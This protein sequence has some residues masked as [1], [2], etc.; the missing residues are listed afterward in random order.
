[1]EDPQAKEPSFH[2]RLSFILME[3]DPDPCRVHN[4]GCVSTIKSATNS[5]LLPNDTDVHGMFKFSHK[6]TPSKLY[7]SAVFSMGHRKLLIFDQ[8]KDPDQSTTQLI[9]S[10]P[11]KN[12]TNV[13][14]VHMHEE[15]MHE[16]T[17]EINALLYSDTE[18]WYDEEEAASTGCSPIEN[19]SVDNEL[20]EGMVQSPVALPCK[21]RRVEYEMDTA[22]EDTAS[23]TNCNSS[24]KESGKKAKCERM[25]E[26][27]GV[28][29]RIIP[30]GK[31]KDAASVLDEAIEY[32]K[33]LRLKVKGL[34][35]T[36]LK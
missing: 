15:E 19:M 36:A 31:G 27:V 14:N 34:E 17:E 13:S 22:L 32:L 12:E 28:L 16:D 2:Q 29:R 9:N 8:S 24:T 6:L 25:Q 1:M 4:V 33:S 26:T 11:R 18:D 21:R 35:V 5:R 20:I 3:T 10:N 7:P 23:S 30:D